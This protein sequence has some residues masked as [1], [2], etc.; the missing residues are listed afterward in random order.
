MREEI[1]SVGI[2][3]GT[4]TTQLIFSRLIIENRASSYMVP[5]ISIV[6]KEVTYQS[7]IY[8]TPLKSQTEIDAE[9]VKEI[10]RGEYRKAGKKPEDLQT[11]A[12]IITGETAR[13]ENANTVLSSLSDMAGDFVVATAGPDL[14]SVLSAR[15]AGT[16]VLSE[17]ERSVI[18]NVDIGGGTSNIAFFQKGTLKGT[19]CL[20]IG[21]RLIKV[22]HGKIS[23]IYPKIQKL[24]QRHGLQIR[25]GDAANEQLL[26]RVCEYMAD[27]LARALHITETD[28]Y[29]NEL[30]T[31]EGKELPREPAVKGIT[32]S[33]GVADCVYRQEAGDVFRYGDIG[34]LLG[35][36]V[37]NNSSL[38][39]LKIYP[40]A[41][42]IRATVVGAGTHTTNVSGST[43]SYAA[44]RLPIKNIP[45]LKVS[46][47][48]E[49][50][51]AAFRNAI[52]NQLSLYETDGALGQIAIAFSGD[53]HTGFSQIQ[54]LAKILMDGAEP[55]IR[56][57]YPLILVIEND[58]A[59]ALGNALNVLLERKKDVICIDGIHAGSG[60][61]ID[62]G[63]PVAGG[64]VVPVV[65][66]TLIFNT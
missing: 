44:G 33:G 23:Y 63:E 59:K 56:S 38:N 32:F 58:I 14:E 22:E 1:L 20:D 62:I 41:E 12:V 40:A 11:G 65:T 48:E 64:R 39:K 47:E 37:R 6:E 29:H 5:R 26:Y 8:F 42:T 28:S 54:E 43:I 4:S 55:V 36:A 3:I 24:A 13:K 35:R 25:V 10:I 27:E 61:Y 53:Y 66:K 21:G 49:Q 46:A 9:K 7:D 18:A 19:C 52:R 51:P 50:E 60:D 34:V 15:G 17:E 45:V 2:D 57:P 16:D 30:Y 31:N